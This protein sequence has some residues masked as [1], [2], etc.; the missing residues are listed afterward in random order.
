MDKDVSLPEPYLEA[1]AYHEAGHAV[2]AVL[3]GVRIER[4]VIGPA[5]E[6]QELNGRVFLRETGGQIPAY[7]VILMAV[8]SEA[9][10]QLAPAFAEASSLHKTHKHLTPFRNGVQNDLAQ[11]FEVAAMAYTLMGHAESTARRLFR[12]EYRD[13]AAGLVALAARAVHRLARKLKSTHSLDGQEVVEIV[14][15]AGPGRRT[16]EGQRLGAALA[17]LQFDSLNLAA[18]RRLACGLAR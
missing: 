4:V 18:A 12:T 11:G 9:A 17:H 3:L 15:R 10:E 14:N 7:V 16:E 2:M 5:C 1:L 6:E 8:A 13:L